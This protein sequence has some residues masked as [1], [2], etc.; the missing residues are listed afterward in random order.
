L[1]FGVYGKLLTNY[2]SSR[3]CFWLVGGGADLPGFA[4]RAIAA[5]RALRAAFIFGAVDGFLADELQTTLAFTAVPDRLRVLAFFVLL[6]LPGLL[7]LA[8]RAAFILAANAFLAAAVMAGGLFLLL[9]YGK[10][11]F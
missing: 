1:W 5:L 2:Q 6:A 7:P 4:R 3:W 9:A 11:Q 10:A 8:A